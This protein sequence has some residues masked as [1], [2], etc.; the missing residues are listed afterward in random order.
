MRA[1][2]SFGWYLYPPMSF[3]LMFDGHEVFATWDGVEGWFP[4]STVQFP[5]FGA[6]FDSFAPDDIKG[7]S[8]PFLS[9]FP[10]PGVVQ[11][12]S[13]LLMRTAPS[14]SL[15]IRPCAN[16]PAT[17][18]FVSFEGLVETDRW[19]GPLFVNLRL[20]RTH[21]PIEFEIGWPIAM[22]Q[23]VAQ[24]AYADASMNCRGV[25]ELA[26]MDAEDWENYRER[27]V[28]PSMVPHRQPGSYAVEARKRSQT[29]GVENLAA[30]ASG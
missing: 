9:A 30:A 10:E 5:D 25:T 13:G 17:K 18:G 4:L 2:A 16:L 21:S 14:W 27:I 29:A 20:L 3:S 15:L 12:W 22:V 26:E 11:L 28:R 1:A 8:P 7:F 19:F 23:P 6:E 24:V